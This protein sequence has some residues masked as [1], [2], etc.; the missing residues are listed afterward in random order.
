VP[1]R[2]SGNCMGEFIYLVSA[3]D[4]LSTACNF[5]VSGGIVH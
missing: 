3:V 5:S 4:M 2:Q 1:L